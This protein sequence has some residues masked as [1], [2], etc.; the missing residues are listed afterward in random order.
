MFISDAFEG[1]ISD[2][3]ITVKSGFLEY[4]EAGDVVLVDKGFTIEDLLDK[5]NATLVRPPFKKPNQGALTEQQ[6]AMTKLI[7]KSRIHVERMNERIKNFKLLDQKIP[8]SLLPLVSQII[9][10]VGCLCNFQEPLA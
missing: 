7:A 2:R 3:D 6:L 8:Q 9:F 5:R 4:I 10:V 1:S